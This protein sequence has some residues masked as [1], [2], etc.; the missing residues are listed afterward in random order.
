[1]LKMI[2]TYYFSYIAVGVSEVISKFW[3]FIFCYKTVAGLKRKNEYRFVKFYHASR[4]IFLFFDLN[5][6]CF[7]DETM[8]G[9]KFTC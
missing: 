5:C 2:K 9:K 4:F 6:V 1:M 7:F 8:D 3:K